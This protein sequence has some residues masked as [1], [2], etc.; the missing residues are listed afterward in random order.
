MKRKPA[1]A[2]NS[3]PELAATL[4][5]LRLV[6]KEIGQNYVASL[7]ADIARLE[8]LLAARAHEPPRPAELRRLLRLVNTLEVKPHKGR[9][10]DLKA[11]DKLV[12]R[13]GGQ[14]EDWE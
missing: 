13:L 6:A 10:R 3:L 12:S 9:R 5:S 8:R 2:D 14:M 1:S 11:I 4:R 7:Q